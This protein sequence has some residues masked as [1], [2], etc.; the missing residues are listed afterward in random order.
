MQPESMPNTSQE[1]PTKSITNAPPQ[2][3][4]DMLDIIQIQQYFSSASGV[5]EPQRLLKGYRDL[6]KV[7]FDSLQYYLTL[8]YSQTLCDTQLQVN[9]LLTAN[10]LLEL[11]A[12]GT[13]KKKMGRKLDSALIAEQEQD[14]LWFA[15]CY[16]VTIDL[17]VEEAH[18]FKERPLANADLI[19]CTARYES[20][21]SEW[22]ALYAE[23]YLV[24]QKE[25]HFFF[26]KNYGPARDLVYLSSIY[27]K[28]L[29][30]DIFFTVPEVCI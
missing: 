23:F 27:L 30:A 25:H 29:I 28:N 8:T 26:A 17:W 21:E 5:F 15:K 12:A 2:P 22:D 18:V 9:V 7:I 3:P 4:Q 24:L 10:R 14:I 11:L 1:T 13:T 19:H 6:S 20:V 16:V